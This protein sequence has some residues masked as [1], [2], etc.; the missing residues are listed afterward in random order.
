MPFKIFLTKRTNVTEKI[1]FLGLKRRKRRRKKI[2]EL[3]E[4]KT[5]KKRFIIHL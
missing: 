4:T 1:Y 5:G 2:S 3:L